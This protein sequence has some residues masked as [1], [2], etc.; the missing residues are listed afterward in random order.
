M[1]LLFS[2]LILG[3]LLFYIIIRSSHTHKFVVFPHESAS[4]IAKIYDSHP[5]ESS[6]SYYTEA[7]AF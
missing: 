7:G 1:Q 4:G 5:E 6:T 3:I 2:S